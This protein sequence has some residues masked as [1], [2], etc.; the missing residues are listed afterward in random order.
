TR[1]RSDAL[2]RRPSA[3]GVAPALRDDPTQRCIAARVGRE[4]DEPAFTVAEGAPGVTVCAQLDPGDGLQPDGAAGGV[5]LHLT[6]HILHVGEP[7]VAEAGSARM[8]H[9]RRYR[10]GTEP[11]RMLALHVQRNKGR[12]RHT[13]P[14]PVTT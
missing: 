9:P 3:A 12:E 14:E 4:H 10:G 2:E 11:D 5:E 13:S 7:G 6:V 8:L 1:E